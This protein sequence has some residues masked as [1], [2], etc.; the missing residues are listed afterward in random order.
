MPG[1]RHMYYAT[2]LPGFMRFGFSPGWIGRSPTGLGPC[3]TYLMTG[4]WGFPQFP[5]YR[6]GWGQAQVPGPGGGAVPSFGM[7][8]EDEIGFLR[9]RAEWLTAQ[10]EEINRR[11]QELEGETA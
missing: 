7:S 3:A 1:Y 8:K 2:G 4:A 10:A 9:Q 11:I 6:E 5:A